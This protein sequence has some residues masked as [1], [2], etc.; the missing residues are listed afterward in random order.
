MALGRRLHLQMVEEDSL[1]LILHDNKSIDHFILKYAKSQPDP[2]KPNS[3]RWQ[4]VNDTKTMI[5]SSS[6]RSDSGRYTLAIGDADENIIMSYSLQLKVQGRTASFFRTLGHISTTK[7][8]NKALM[9]VLILCL[10][11]YLWLPFYNVVT[12]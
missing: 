10:F 8:M 9:A 2:L 5:L 1:Y 11:T 12:R 4:F 6:E 7:N 3:P